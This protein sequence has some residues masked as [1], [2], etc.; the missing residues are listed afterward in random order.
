MFYQFAGNVMVVSMPFGSRQSRTRIRTST[1]VSK[2]HRQVQELQNKLESSE[3]QRDAMRKRLER[4]KKSECKASPHTPKPTDSIETITYEEWLKTVK[5][6]DKI[7]EENSSGADN[8]DL[9]ASDSPSGHD[10]PRITELMESIGQ[11]TPKSRTNKELR[12]SG[13]SPRRVP[14]VMRKKLLYANVISEELKASAAKD[15]R[16]K[17]V[18]TNVL[19]GKVVK[20]YRLQEQARAIIGASKHTYY[21]ADKK[22]MPHKKIRLNSA[23][24][25]KVVTFL[26][27][28]DNARTNP[29]K[30]DCVKTEKSKVQTK[31]L[32][33][34]MHN[35]YVKFSAEN[36]N[37]KISLSTF[38]K[39]RPQNSLLTSYLSKSNCLCQKHQNC[40]L[41]LKAL[42]KV[43]DGTVQVTY[44]PDTMISQYPDDESVTALLEKNWLWCRNIWRMAKSQGWGWE[45][46]DKNSSIYHTQE[47]FCCSL[48]E[49]N[50]RISRTCS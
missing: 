35:L 42:I 26:G 13:I 31:T 7:I 17:R 4:T 21:K 41:K 22:F 3:R 27:R 37:I 38:C 10:V 11:L 43:L 23:I 18:L 33:D 50:Y 29:G 49:S 45:T 39:L 19:S 15:I 44:N 46:Q 1:A 32:L 14:P 20:K 28:E 40:A 36:P 2:L 34:Y 8:E 48:W 24:K 47:R 9:Y 12:D 25:Q 30:R 16:L 5:S 6:P